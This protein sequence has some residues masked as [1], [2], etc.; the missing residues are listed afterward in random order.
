MRYVSSAEFMVAFDTAARELDLG[1]A[2]VA[3]WEML[4]FNVERADG[5]P[6]L[7]PLPTPGFTALVKERV[8]PRI[9][10][11]L[12][13]RTI[14]ERSAPRDDGRDC[15]LDA[16]FLD[17]ESGNLVV[18]WEFENDIRGTEDDE[19]GN[20]RAVDAPLKVLVTCL[21]PTGRD[22][23]KGWLEDYAQAYANVPN[24]KQTTGTFV[25]I[26]S[27]PDGRWSFHEFEG[28][29]AEATRFRT[30]SV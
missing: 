2:A 3:N 18:A 16:V 8:V 4:G 26:F 29:G 5:R 22:N 30:V 13:L 27:L 25:V 12:H 6:R 23:P 10:E 21:R 17:P 7:E 11:L 28:S 24:G 9:A 1:G 15:R 14:P 19:V 20:L